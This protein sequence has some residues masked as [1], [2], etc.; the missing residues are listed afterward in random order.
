MLYNHF[1][2]RGGKPT[3]TR[4]QEDFRRFCCRRENALC[5]SRHPPTPVGNPK[6]GPGQSEYNGHLVQQLKMASYTRF[7]TPP[8]S[9]NSTA[10]SIND[11]VSPLTRRPP[12][13]L[14]VHK[15]AAADQAWPLQ[16]RLRPNAIHR[17]PSVSAQNGLGRH[18][19]ATSAGW[20]AFSS[21]V[22]HAEHRSQQ[23]LFGPWSF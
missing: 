1:I 9:A 2:L 7:L 4:A 19:P 23:R 5:P 11:L 20:A 18:Q 3:K 6:P 14:N 15:V 13:L 16:N 12:P 22:F 10:F 21:N 8:S 17:P